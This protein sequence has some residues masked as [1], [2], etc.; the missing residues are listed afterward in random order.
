MDNYFSDEYERQQI[1]NWT[2]HDINYQLS[3]RD[4]RI[5]E[6]EAEIG[7]LSGLLFK[8]SKLLAEELNI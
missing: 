2:N 3:L 5:E 6:L 1:N 4:Q 8:F 7:R